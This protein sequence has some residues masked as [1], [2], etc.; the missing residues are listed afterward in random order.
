MGVKLMDLGNG[1]SFRD[2]A[3]C[4]SGGKRKQTADVP[5]E[6]SQL[7]V[8]ASIW[9]RSIVTFEKEKEH[10]PACLNL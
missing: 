2:R 8:L 10:G 7:L 4:Q 6:K 3:R 9:R 5:V 1:E